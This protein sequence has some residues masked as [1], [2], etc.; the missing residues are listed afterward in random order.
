MM[1]SYLLCDDDDPLHH[2]YVIEDGICY[3][4]LAEKTYPKKLAFAFLEDIKDGFI[5][6]LQSDHGDE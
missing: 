3:L 1:M 6:E 2:S 5:A 4:T